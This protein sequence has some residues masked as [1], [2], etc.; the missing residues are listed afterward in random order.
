MCNVGIASGFSALRTVGGFLPAPWP[1]GI[2][3]GETR[4]RPDG[5]KAT[6]IDV[7]F[8]TVTAAEGDEALKAFKAAVAWLPAFARSIRRVEIG[9]DTSVGVDCSFSPLL[10]ESDICVVS[11]SGPFRERALRL[12]L[13]SGFFLLLRVNAAGP[14]AFP[15]DLRRLWNLAPLEEELR[16]GW[17]LNGPFT[18]DPGRT[19]LAGSIADRREKFRKLGRAF[20]D[21]LLKLHDLAVGDW[22]RFAGGLDLDAS[23]TKAWGI[24]WSHLFDVLKPDLDDDLARY[25]HADG[26]GYAYLAGQRQVVPTRLTSWAT[27]VWKAQ[28]SMSCMTGFPS[29]Y[30][31]ARSS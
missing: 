7:P 25:L 13:S 3:V 23:G 28:A 26:H 9:G 10:D 21:S 15:N 2:D 29:P 31:K 6:V 27:A 14:C 20:G 8:S 22:S 19:G 18:V 12:D 5:R 30:G 24:F 16:S 17:M 11:V 1:E 4:K